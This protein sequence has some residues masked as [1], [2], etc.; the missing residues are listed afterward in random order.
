MRTKKE[1]EAAMG[2]EI[3]RFEQDYM[4]RVPKDIHVCLSDDLILIRLRG[5]LSPAESE[6]GQIASGRERAGFG[7]VNSMSLARNDPP[8][9]GGDC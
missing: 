1:I 5:I 3:N 4:N 8:S 7:Q 9:H 6:R 2:E